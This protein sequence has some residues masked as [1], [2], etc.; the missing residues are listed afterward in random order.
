MTEKAEQLHSYDA[1]DEE[2]GGD[3]EEDEACARQ[4]YGEGLGDLVSVGD[5]IEH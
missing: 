3:E 4:D 5:L 2:D 1:V